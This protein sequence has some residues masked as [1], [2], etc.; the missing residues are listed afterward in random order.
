MSIASLC[1]ASCVGCQRDTAHAFAAECL[2]AARAVGGGA[3]ENARHENTGRSNM[4]DMNL[5]HQLARLENAK[6]ENAVPNCRGG[7]CGKS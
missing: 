1:S 6:H 5:R 7:K 2:V 4:R 3:T